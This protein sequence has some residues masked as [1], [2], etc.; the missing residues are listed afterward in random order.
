MSKSRTKTEAVIEGLRELL[1]QRRIER[2]LS[3]VGK[4]E[5]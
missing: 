2:I 4:P 3:S 1:L 5:F